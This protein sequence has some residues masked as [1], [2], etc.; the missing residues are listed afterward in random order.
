M[1]SSAE[2]ARLRYLDQA[3]RELVVASP[4]VSAHL[5]VA[6]RAVKDGNDVAALDHSGKKHGH[7]CRT[8]GT[9]L[10]PSW[11]CQALRPKSIK[12]S[13]KGND[14]EPSAPGQNSELAIRC[15]TCNAVHKIQVG[16]PS[17]KSRN[18]ATVTAA[19]LTKLIASSQPIQQLPASVTKV[20]GMPAT[21]PNKRARGKRST[22]QA[23]LANKKPQAAN[24]TSY[25]LD[26]T[27]F[28]KT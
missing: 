11:N 2:N 20:S 9:V 27:D 21:T 16:T 26:L 14:R 24:G 19:T 8:C 1:T 7:V 28:M 4:A 22:L 5:Q 12:G 17:R 6:R 23:L 3:S 25:G 13:R 18:A 10:L 15:N